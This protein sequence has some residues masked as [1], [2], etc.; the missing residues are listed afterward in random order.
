VLGV[1]NKM[2]ERELEAVQVFPRVANVAHR[3]YAIELVD[4]YEPAPG[5]GTAPDKPTRVDCPF[6]LA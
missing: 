2:G 6:G 5:Q 3:E 4:R 1:S